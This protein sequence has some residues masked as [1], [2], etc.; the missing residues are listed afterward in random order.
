MSLLIRLDGVG[1]NL[2]P[3]NLSVA[4][5]Q[6]QPKNLSYDMQAYA[7]TKIVRDFLLNISS[8]YGIGDCVILLV[9]IV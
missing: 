3:V 7:Y 6:L 5:S 8:L 2:L 1:Q 4:H 9:N